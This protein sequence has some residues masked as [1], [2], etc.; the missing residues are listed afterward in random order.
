MVVVAFSL[1]PRIWKEGLTNQSVPSFLGVGGLGLDEGVDWLV[2]VSLCRPGTIYSG[3]VSCSHAT[4]G[5][6]GTQNTLQLICLFLLDLK[7][8]G[9]RGYLNFTV[10]CLS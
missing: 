2:S 4:Q 8:I 10:K 9:P 5:V 1:Q 7:N 3:S 6:T